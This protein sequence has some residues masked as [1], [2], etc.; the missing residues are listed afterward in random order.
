[1]SSSYFEMFHAVPATITFTTNQINTTTYIKGIKQYIRI[2]F[3]AKYFG[4]SVGFA[5]GNIRA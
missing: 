3:F 5:W 2:L 1:M 4:A